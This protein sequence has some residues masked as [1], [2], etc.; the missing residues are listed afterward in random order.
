[1]RI[2]KH[3][4]LKQSKKLKH[5]VRPLPIPERFVHKNVPYFCQW[6]SP[7][8]AKQIVEHTVSTDDDPN[9]KSSGAKT[10]D[11]YHDWSW[12]ACGMACT[13]M[14]LARRTGH[15]APIVEL[16]RECA[17][18]GGYVMPLKAS[19]GLYFKPYITFVVERFQWKA[20]IIQGV[21]VQEL[22]YELG[23]GNYV[24]AGVNAQI[25]YPKSIPTQKNGHLIL[26]LGYD[27]TKQEFYFH[28]PSGISKETQEYATIKYNDFKRFFSGRGIVVSD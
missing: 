24:I 21:T 10:K 13:K 16:G 1:M 12:S 22:M 14:L 6:E 11:E 26:L 19:I 28:N 23:K 27:K 2:I 5:F 20:K 8:L 9:W 17:K 18:Y 25:R 15:I 7:E 3:H 4:V